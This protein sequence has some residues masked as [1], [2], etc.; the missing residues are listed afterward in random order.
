LTR[1]ALTVSNGKLAAKMIQPLHRGGIV[2][3]VYSQASQ[4]LGHCFI[5]N[6]LLA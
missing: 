5:G 3:R 1:F 2:A 6:V 4:K